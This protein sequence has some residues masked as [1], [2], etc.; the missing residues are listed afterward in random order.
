LAIH[1]GRHNEIFPSAGATRIA[2]D[3]F[4]PKN[5]DSK[6]NFLGAPCPA[7]DTAS[8]SGFGTPVAKQKNREL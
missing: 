1:V 2:I 5:F 8:N 7:L 4:D 3:F 6:A